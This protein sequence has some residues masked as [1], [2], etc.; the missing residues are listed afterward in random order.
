MTVIY[1]SSAILVWAVLDADGILAPVALAAVSPLSEAERA[2][3]AEQIV[4]PGATLLSQI[5]TGDREEL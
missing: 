1:S 2:T 4:D 5:V 3:L